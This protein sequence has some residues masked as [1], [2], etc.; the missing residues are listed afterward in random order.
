MNAFEPKLFRAAM[1]LFTTGV[2]VITFPA[3]GEPAGMTANAFMSVSIAPP[4]VVVSVRTE[5]R[6]N[7][8]VKSAE[9]FGI[10]FLAEKQQY[11]SAHFGGKRQEGLEVPF[12]YEGQTP[13]IEGSL[14]H[15]VART[16]AIHAAGDHFLYVG[17]VEH[18]RLGEQRKP[19]VFFGGKYKQ[20]DAHAPLASWYV[21]DEC[22]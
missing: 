2:T 1:G 6:F 7:D 17:Q 5:S 14:A 3:D 13:L 8:Y 18:L 21:N 20:I 19:L 16:V 10:S 22:L 15:I 12:I 11:L 4:L 9:C